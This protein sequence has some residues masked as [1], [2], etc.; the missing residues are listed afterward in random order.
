MTHWLKHRHRC[1]HRCK[2]RVADEIDGTALNFPHTT[3][4]AHIGI[5]CNGPEIRMCAMCE[6]TAMTTNLMVY[7]IL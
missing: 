1:N 6:N 5:D 3:V 4:Y 2:R 7:M